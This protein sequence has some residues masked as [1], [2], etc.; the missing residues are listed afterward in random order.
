MTVIEDIAEGIKPTSYA[1]D[2]AENDERVERRE[3]ACALLLLARICKTERE[4]A[5]LADEIST[6]YLMEDERRLLYRRFRELITDTRTERARRA[7][8]EAWEETCAYRG[9]SQIHSQDGVWAVWIHALSEALLAYAQ[10]SPGI[11]FSANTFLEL[12]REEDRSWIGRMI[13]HMRPQL[14][15][16]GWEKSAIPSRKLS[17]VRVYRLRP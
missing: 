2:R 3:L 4:F 9:L 10:A 11:T 8:H 15:T 1:K 16:T 5:E 6:T 13:Q 17:G 12:V 7:M 14:E